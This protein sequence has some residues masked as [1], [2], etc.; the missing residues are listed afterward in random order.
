MEHEKGLELSRIYGSIGEKV[1]DQ[2]TDPEEYIQQRLLSGYL[3]QGKQ[4]DMLYWDVSSGV[5][6]DEAKNSA[7]FLHCSGVKEQFP[8]P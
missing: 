2:T 8:K 1:W 7:W 6:G 3:G 5:F 4:L